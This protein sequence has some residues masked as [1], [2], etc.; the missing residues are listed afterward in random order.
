MAGI[1]R[2]AEVKHRGRCHRG[3]GAGRRRS[4]LQHGCELVNAAHAGAAPAGQYQQSLAAGRSFSLLR[5]RIDRELGLIPEISGHRLMVSIRWMRA[6]SEGRLRP[7]TEDTAFE[8]TL[9][10]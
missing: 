3:A 9:C 2:R 1:L 8:L 4:R 7:H 5:V 10:A 6:D